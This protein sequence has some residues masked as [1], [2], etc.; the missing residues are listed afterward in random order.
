M[1]I[2]TYPTEV[3]TLADYRPH[4]ENYNVHSARQLEALAASLDNLKQFKNI[5]VWASPNSEDGVDYLGYLI[6]GHG[7]AEAASTLLGA[8]TI[9]AK[10]VP[11][12]TELHTVRAIMAA[13]NELARMSTVDPEMLGTVLDGIREE[14]SG[15]LQATGWDSESLDSFI[16]RSKRPAGSPVPIEFGSGTMPSHVTQSPYFDAPATSGGSEGEPPGGGEPEIVHFD[17]TKL[18]GAVAEGGKKR[19]FLLYVSF[20]TVED[21]AAA[22]RLLTFGERKDVRENSAFAS[23]DGEKYLDG[24]LEYLPK[25]ENEVDEDGS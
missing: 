2:G 25:I 11:A 24:W 13:D 4:P 3:I 23:V 16:A 10:I 22:L 14:S 21:F 9:E 20:S 6:A 7:L 12:D 8:T 17:A 1:T 15:T 19:T 18:A 5:V